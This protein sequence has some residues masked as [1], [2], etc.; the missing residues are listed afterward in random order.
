MYVYVKQ[1]NIF[2]RTP[3]G[4]HVHNQTNASKTSKKSKTIGWFEAEIHSEQR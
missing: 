4:H 2:H 1:K 3:F